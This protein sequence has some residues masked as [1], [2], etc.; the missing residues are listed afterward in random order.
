MSYYNNNDYNYNYPNNNNEHNDDLPGRMKLSINQNAIDISTLSDDKKSEV[1]HLTFGNSFNNT[2]TLQHMDNFIKTLKQF[3]NLISLNMTGIGLIA[4]S[5]SIDELPNLETLILSNNH[6]LNELPDSIGT[7]VNLKEFSIQMTS[8]EELPASF[9]RL[10]KLQIVNITHT[11][12]TELPEAIVKLPELINLNITHS[13]I[14]SLP[15]NFGDLNSLIE[16]RAISC[17]ITSLPDSIGNL[18]ELTEL[19]LNSCQLTSL[20]E[21]I[22]NL[23]Q[24][25][26]LVLSL[27]R[28]TILPDTIGNLH[29]LEI[30]KLNNNRI[31]SLPNTIGDLQQLKELD[32]YANQLTTLPDSIF[33]IHTLYDVDISNNRITSL[34]DLF[35]QLVNLQRLNISANRL[36]VIPPSINA[37]RNRLE[38]YNNEANPATTHIFNN[39]LW[40]NNNANPWEEHHIAPAFEVHNAFDKINKDAL[41]LFFKKYYTLDLPT[42]DSNKV[43]V[44]YMRSILDGF[45]SLMKNNNSKKSNTLK[46][47]DDIFTNVLNGIMYTQEYMK[48]IAYSLEYANMQSDD[49]KIAYVSTFTYDC[50]HAYN[51]PS[52]LSCAKGMIERFVLSLVTAATLYAGSPDYSAKGYEELVG[53]ILNKPKVTPAANS[54]PLKELMLELS[55]DCYK[56]SE[57]DEDEFRKCI[58]AKVAE[59]LGNSYDETAADQELDVVIPILA[60]FGGRR[61]GKRSKRIWK[62]RRISHKGTSHK[63]T[64]HKGKKSARKTAVR[65]VKKLVKRT[66]RGSTRSTKRSTRGVIRRR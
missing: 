62:T 19:N 64:N 48:I 46:D 65:A 55:E 16:F 39:T 56:E 53:I 54:N 34:Q 6:Q 35:N 47:I 60:L 30:L 37:I 17:P 3:P 31:I 58:K 11:Y 57:G 21:S 51:G 15:D 14:A 41:F 45:I 40:R 59:R 8:I 24:L 26:T 12:F 61:G 9:E 44:D 2:A 1:T 32:V 20:P 23:Q 18:Q 49:F 50:A 4:L 36:E 28:L 33:E 7:L 63:G 38:Y 10:I 13:S 27:N 22:G 43:F 42:F 52:P 25:H 29:N 5:E 66:T